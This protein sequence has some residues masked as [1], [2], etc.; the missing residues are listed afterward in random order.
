[1]LLNPAQHPEF[2]YSFKPVDSAM[3]GGQPRIDWLAAD[4][5][6]RFWMIEVK[7]LAANRKTF[8]LDRDVS[9]GQLSALHAL[10]TTG[11]GVPLLAVGQAECLYIFDW[12]KIEWLLGLSAP[13]LLKMSDCS[14]SLM[15][16]GPKS[17]RLI[18]LYE[19][20]A[21]VLLYGRIPSPSAPPPGSAAMP[22]GYVNP[23]LLIPPV[24]S[25]SISKQPRSTRTRRKEILSAL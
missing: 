10:S 24:P 16:A 6:G 12:R 14:L 11:V 22:P 13:P 2:A 21:P 19:S 20:L 3:Y 1:M 17:W 7:S 18:N 5:V 8:S 4:I 25:P 9:P 23:L 15:W